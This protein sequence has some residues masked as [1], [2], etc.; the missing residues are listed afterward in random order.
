MKRYFPASLFYHGL[1]GG[2]I[3]ADDRSVTYHTGKVTVPAAYK[4]IEMPYAQIAEAV[5]GRWFL[6]PTVSLAMRGGEQ[7]RFVVFG[8]KRFL[9]LLKEHGVN[10]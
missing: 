4:R 7:Y 10:G 5:R 1:L 6:F 3:V 9:A 2:G 8:Q